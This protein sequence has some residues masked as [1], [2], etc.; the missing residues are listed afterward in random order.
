MNGMS[1]AKRFYFSVVKNLISERMPD[2]VENY[3]AGLI[4]YGSDVLGNDDEVSRDHEWG[5]RLHLFLAL[6]SY[7]RRA[8]AL[9]QLLRD[10]LPNSFEGFPTRFA[11]DDDIG[12]MTVEPTGVHHV[13]IT[14]PERFLQLT[15]GIPSVPHSAQDW[16][17][18]PEQ[19]LL[20]FTRGEIFEDYTGTV[21]NLRSGFHYFPEHVW[22]YRLA[23]LLISASW[24]YDLISL[25]GKSKD[26]LSMYICT[27][28]TIERIMKITFVLNK[29]YCPYR[30]WLHR[31]FGKLTSVAS[32]LASYLD[33]ARQ[34][35]DP[36]SLRNAIDAAFDVIV[37][38][39]SSDGICDAIPA[40]QRY[41][42]GNVK[43][44]LQK[45][46]RSIIVELPPEIP[47]R[48]KTGITLGGVDQWIEN[49][50]AL[51]SPEFLLAAR[52]MYSTTRMTRDQVGDLL[53]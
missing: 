46:A 18:I 39:L 11:F 1:L 35:N 51:L 32:D 38:R 52:E 17:L 2:L 40:R 43:Y 21:T 30:K 47:A 20:E 6:D 48:L 10:H 44:D 36:A 23:Y 16:L 14:T 50:D 7:Q 3:A 24:E 8:G 22:K 27:A 49:E 53:I 31:E 12:V 28:L 42:R 15:I 41:F 5:P 9:D 19:R 26:Y 25:C 29:T 37:G 13:V 33:A 34:E 4:G 45:M